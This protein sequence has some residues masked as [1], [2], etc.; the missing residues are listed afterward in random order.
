MSREETP[1]VGGRFKAPQPSVT[2]AS[3]LMR[4]LRAVIEPLML[5][6]LD[7]RQQ[8]RFGCAVALI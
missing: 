4:V 6:M 8:L 2:F 5:A 3:G 7:A 1:G